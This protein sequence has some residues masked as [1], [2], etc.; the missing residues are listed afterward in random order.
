MDKFLKKAGWTSILTSVIFAIIGIIMIYNPTTIMMFISTIL[1]VFFVIIGIIKLINY[2]IGK[3]NNSTL[4][5]ND[6]AWGMI[7]IIIGLVIMV[8][9]GAIESILRIMIGIWIIY[10][11]FMRLTV[12]FRL[13]NINT[14][15]WVFVL[16]LAVAMIVGGIYV[17]FYPGAL[18]V[19][20]G[21][22]IL[23]Y[24]LMD[25]IESFIFMRNM[26]DIL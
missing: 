5:S 9:S 6:I 23:V 14:K 4:F 12:S 15:L 21:V 17:T 2:F 10:S 11:G 18:I 16:I 22:I 8:Y 26:K 3:G 19:T 20:L 1:G 25:L 13:K 7:A 24:A